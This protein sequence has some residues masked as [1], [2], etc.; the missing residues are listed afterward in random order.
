MTPRMMKSVSN[1]NR[2]L[3]QV[4]GAACLTG[5][6]AYAAWSVPT[7]SAAESRL[8]GKLYGQSAGGNRYPIPHATLQFCLPSGGCVDTFTGADGSYSVRVNQGANYQVIA[9][10]RDGGFVSE[11]VYI[12]RG[13]RKLDILAD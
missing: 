6:V 12:G 11:N 5:L 7:P 2:S 9:P 3:S 4:L 10:S 1:R 13:V 8:T